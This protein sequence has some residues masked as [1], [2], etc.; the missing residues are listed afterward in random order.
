MTHCIE[1]ELELFHTHKLKSGLGLADSSRTD[2]SVMYAVK[3]G[4]IQADGHR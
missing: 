2:H 1:M 4:F 3:S